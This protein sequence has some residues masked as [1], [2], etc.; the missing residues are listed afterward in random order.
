MAQ[1]KPKP[2]TYQSARQKMITKEKILVAKLMNN[3]NVL[4][5]YEETYGTRHSKIREQLVS[6]IVRVTGAVQQR[7]RTANR[8]HNGW[9]RDTEYV[10]KQ[11]VGGFSSKGKAFA[12]RLFRLTAIWKFYETLTKHSWDGGLDR[13][14]IVDFIGMFHDTDELHNDAGQY[15]DALDFILEQYDWAF[16]F[17]S[18]KAQRTHK[19]QERKAREEKQRKRDRQYEERQQWTD[20]NNWF[21]GNTQDA[22]VSRKDEW[23][24]RRMAAIPKDKTWFAI[25][26]VTEK[27]S[28]R[29]VKKAFRSL[30][31]AK[32]P[33]VPSGDADDFMMVSEAYEVYNKI[34]EGA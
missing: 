9:L 3:S 29:D 23:A 10:R 28:P 11:F 17:F 5:V 15:D 14:D 30:S 20:W 4:Y 31:K 8:T 22:I 19:E 7:V 2:M 1:N 18:D 32:H 6:D 12:K 33:D 24:Y 13:D 34:Q 21:D 16:D 26:D 25:L 27:A